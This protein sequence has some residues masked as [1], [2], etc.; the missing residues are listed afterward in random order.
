MQTAAA[1]DPDVSVTAIT[2]PRRDRRSAER[3]LTTFRTGRLTRDCGDELCIIRN[4][5]PGGAMVHVGD[6]YAVDETV[7]LDLRFNEQLSAAVAWVR[8]RTIGLRFERAVDLADLFVSR[9]SNGA[10]ARAPRLVVPASGRLQVGHD[11]FQVVTAD[12]SQGGAKIYAGITL[13][14]GTM[15]RLWLD[16][17]CSRTCTIRWCHGGAAG[18]AFDQAL[19]VT[20]LSAWARH[21]RANY[22]RMMSHAT[23]YYSC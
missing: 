17:F 18:V 19:C 8:D 5:S 21:Q 4:I 23:T 2:S 7:K 14:H 22:F 13:K 9:A 3:Q 20:D 16:E 15:G 12:V 6:Q 11:M 1:K 10:R